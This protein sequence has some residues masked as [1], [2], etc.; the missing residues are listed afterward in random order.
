MHAQ[1]NGLVPEMVEYPNPYLNVQCSE[2]I[3]HLRAPHYKLPFFP[4]W[5][6]FVQILLLILCAVCYDGDNV[7]MEN[8]WANHNSFRGSNQLLFYFFKTILFA[9]YYNPKLRYALERNML[10]QEAI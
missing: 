6:Y 4:T 3:G 8:A 10:V 9:T 1:L 7:V 2:R 5:T